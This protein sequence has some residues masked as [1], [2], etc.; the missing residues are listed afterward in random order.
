MSCER[1]AIVAETFLSTFFPYFLC[2]SHA[3]SF[4]NQIVCTCNTKEL[5]KWKKLYD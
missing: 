5:L 2:N 1:C 4:F 3:H